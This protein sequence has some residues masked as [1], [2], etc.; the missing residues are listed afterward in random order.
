MPVAAPEPFDQLYDG[1]GLVAPGDI[2]GC[3]FEGGFS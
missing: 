2:V 3:E 1:L